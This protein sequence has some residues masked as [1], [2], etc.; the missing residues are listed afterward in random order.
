LGFPGG[1]RYCYRRP[2]AIVR[3]REASF[4]GSAR[5]ANSS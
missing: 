2:T 4:L 5:S 3:D 1:Q